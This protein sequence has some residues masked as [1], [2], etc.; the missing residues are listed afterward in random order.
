MSEDDF[1]GMNYKDAEKEFREMGF[2]TFEYKTVDT[3]NES[4]AD[5]ICYIEIT[6]FFIGDAKQYN[7]RVVTFDNNIIGL[8]VETY[9]PDMFSVI[10]RINKRSENENERA[11]KEHLCKMN[12]ISYFGVSAKTRYELAD[13]IKKIFQ[14]KNIYI[15]SN[16]QEDI[17][18]CKKAFFKWKDIIQI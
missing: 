14:E 13:K 1:K 15:L 6:E 16:S 5:T 3:E 17:E 10:E 8:P 2:T 12:G 7:M 9:I 18:K 11:V 4:A